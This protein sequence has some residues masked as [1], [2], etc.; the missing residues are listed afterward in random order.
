MLSHAMLHLS[1]FSAFNMSEFITVN[2][3]VAGSRSVL[4]FDTV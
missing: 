1:R 3:G 2:Q 4:P